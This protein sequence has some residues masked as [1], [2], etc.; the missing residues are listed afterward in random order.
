[1]E[2]KE[3]FVYTQSVDTVMKFFGDKAAIEVKHAK[4][5]SRNVN[6]ETCKLTKTSLDMKLNKETPLDVPSVLKKFLGEW[7][8]ATQEE[9]WTGSAAKGFTGTLKVDLKGVP[10]KL[11]G[12]YN[13]TGNAKGSNLEVTLSVTCGIPLIGGK[14][15]EFIGKTAKENMQLEYDY[16]LAALK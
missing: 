12:T 5:G 14:L 1:M 9:S 3:N 15:A 11:N 6:V 10:V 16:N 4:L 8:A 13:L 7:Q 2:I